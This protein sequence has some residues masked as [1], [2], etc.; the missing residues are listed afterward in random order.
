MEHT[1]SWIGAVRIVRYTIKN[2]SLMQ[3]TVLLTLPCVLYI[4]INMW[5][6][7]KEFLTCFIRQVH[8]HIRDEENPNSQCIN[9][10]ENLRCF[11]HPKN[12]GGFQDITSGFCLVF[13]E[14]TVS[15][16]GAVHIMRC[17]IKNLSLVQN[18]VLLTLPCVLYTG[19]PRIAQI[20]GP[21]TIVLLEELC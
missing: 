20:L 17:T 9:A 15:W 19:G 18:T 4:W 12:R 1:V 10:L 11:Y 14:H 7:Y 3:N 5:I 6:K 16:I 13:M 2:L 21:R 8:S